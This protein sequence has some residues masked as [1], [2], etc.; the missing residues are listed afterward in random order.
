M[1]VCEDT[2]GMGKTHHNKKI[3]PYGKKSNPMEIQ[4]YGKKDFLTH[5]FGQLEFSSSRYLD[6]L[7]LLGPDIFIPSHVVVP[8]AGTQSK[9][10]S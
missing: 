9:P 5:Y 7:S 2:E 3:Q 1:L 6:N 4:P 10:L 8:F